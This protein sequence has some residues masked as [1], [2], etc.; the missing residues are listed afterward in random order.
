[1]TTDSADVTAANTFLI[2]DSDG[3]R[4]ALATSIFF[5]GATSRLKTSNGTDICTGRARFT[6]Q[7]ANAVATTSEN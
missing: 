4:R 1:M 5:I 6:D 2:S 7:L 3:V